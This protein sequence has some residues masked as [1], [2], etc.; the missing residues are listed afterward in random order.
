L[1]NAQNELK[2]IRENK[3]QG[4]IMRAKEEERNTQYFCQLQKKYRENNTKINKR[5]WN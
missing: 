1:V 5:R 4:I 3:V 2:T